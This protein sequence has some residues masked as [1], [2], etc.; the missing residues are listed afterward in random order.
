M[1]MMIGKDGQLVDTE[2]SEYETALE[3]KAASVN[4]ATSNVVVIGGT[5]LGCLYVTSCSVDFLMSAKSP[6][7]DKPAAEASA[8]V[9]KVT[10]DTTSIDRSFDR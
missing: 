9:E 5:L 7:F 8:L 2:P 4:R 3:Q 6:Q 1:G 10:L